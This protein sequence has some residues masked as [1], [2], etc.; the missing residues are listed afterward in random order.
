MT[1]LDQTSY[2]PQNLNPTWNESFYLLCF[3]AIDE[4]L[5]LEV[6]DHD[7][8]TSHDPL[9]YC[10][11]SMSEVIELA[12]SGLCA[13]KT[14]ELY[15]TSQCGRVPFQCR[16]HQSIAECKSHCYGQLITSFQYIPLSNDDDG[17]NLIDEGAT[18]RAE[19]SKADVI[20]SYNTTKRRLTYSYGYG[21]VDIGEVGDKIGLLTVHSIKCNNFN[22]KFTKGGIFRKS[23]KERLLYVKVELEYDDPNLKD[24]Q[25]KRTL[26]ALR[27]K[28]ADFPNRFHYIVKNLRFVPSRRRGVLTPKVVWKDELSKREILSSVT[29]CLHVFDDRS[30]QYKTDKRLGTVRIRLEEFVES[31]NTFIARHFVSSYIS[32]PSLPVVHQQIH[33]Q[34]M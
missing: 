7:F 33:T 30:S 4:L 19:I 17:Q 22:P 25:L 8:V 24:T 14:F 5:E 18:E 26:T 10:S 2:I 6:F 9:G 29:L 32:M 11:I 21:I 31:E 1:Q 3:K 28:D 34:T 12:K 13:D 20:Q 16:K 23:E 15:E 27:G